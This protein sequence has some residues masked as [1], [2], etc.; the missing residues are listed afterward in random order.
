MNY[1]LKQGLGVYTKDGKLLGQVAELR[2][3]EFKVDAPMVLDYWLPNSCIE[4]VR[5]ETVLLR[6]GEEALAPYKRELGTLVEESEPHT[7]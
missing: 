3:G 7:V 2:G 5:Y 1:G 4:S 6:V